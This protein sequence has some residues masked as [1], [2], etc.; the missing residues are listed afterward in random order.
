MGTSPSLQ[1]PGRRRD[2]VIQPGERTF[3]QSCNRLRL[4]ADGKVKSCLFSEELT[5]LKFLLRSAPRR[6]TGEGADEALLEQTGH[7]W[8]YRWRDERCHHPMVK[9]GG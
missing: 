3:C 2:R 4:T 5:D 6:G 1:L 9:I 7:P 8:P